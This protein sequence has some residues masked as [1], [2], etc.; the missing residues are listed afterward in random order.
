MSLVSSK[1][2]P[3][4][5]NALC[6]L[7]LL[8]G[9]LAWVGCESSEATRQEQDQEALTNLVGDRKPE[10]APP[11]PP[12]DQQKLAALEAENTN[13]KQKIT[14]LEQDNTTLSARLSELEAKL[15]AEREQA[16]KAVAPKVPPVGT[17]YEDW[18]KAFG[19]KL[20]DDAIQVFQAL[21]DGNVGEE[22][23]DN[24]HYWIGESNFG[25]KGYAEAL[26]EFEVVL[27]Y[28]VSEKKG[29]ALFMM[30]QCYEITGDKAKAKE[31]YEKVVKD[32]PTS[33]L[34]N[35]ARERWGRL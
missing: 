18:I 4:W 22:L 27:Q 1:G 12:V 33:N 35:K 17:S 30:A 24:C 34:V 14:K 28:K 2:R 15:L 32:Y 11:A 29:D 10:I 8:T 9:V 3:S 23:A 25:K 16:E 20:Y 13:L 19:E 21:L 5:M 6:F 31:M 26:K 7:V